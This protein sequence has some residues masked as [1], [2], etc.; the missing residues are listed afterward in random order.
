MPARARIAVQARGS[1]GGPIT[2]TAYG[3]GALPIVMIATDD[4]YPVISDT[5]GHSYITIDSIEIQHYSSTF[6]GTNSQDGIQ[7]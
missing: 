2:T 5:G 3:K 4:N 7:F 6:G 1:A